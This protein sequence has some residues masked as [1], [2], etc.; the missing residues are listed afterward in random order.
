MMNNGVKPDDIGNVVSLLSKTSSKSMAEKGSVLMA[1]VIIMTTVVLLGLTISG[2]SLMGAKRSVATQRSLQTYY[3]AMAGVQQAMAT[4]FYP[5]SNYLAWNPVADFID[6][7]PTSGNPPDPNSGLVFQDPQNPGGSNVIGAFQYVILGG[8]QGVADS[9][10]GSTFNYWADNDNNNESPAKPKKIG[11]ERFPDSDQARFVIVSRAVTCTDPDGAVQPGFLDDQKLGASNA[12]IP[13]LTPTCTGG[14]EADTLTVVATVWV[15]PDSGGSDRVERTQVYKDDSAI[16]L[17]RKTFLPGIGW[18]NRGA[19]FA[20]DDVYAYDGTG[21]NNP[22]I[23]SHI[24]FYD[25]VDDEIQCSQNI[26]GTSTTI[27]A[28]AAN[29]TNKSVVQLYFKGAIDHRSI[30]ANDNFSWDDCKIDQNDCAIQIEDGGGFESG[31]QMIYQPPKN[32]QIKL[33]PTLG[34]LPGAGA[35]YTITVNTADLRSW[36]GAPGPATPYEIEFTMP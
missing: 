6:P 16:R 21:T 27:G 2:I 32:N 30:D 22:V 31:Y 1:A 29:I 33:L 17:P 7:Y 23:P 25:F 15:K 9:S 18:Q 26:T 10:S 36:S 4:R 24:V 19:T 35:T 13:A 14:M 28:C 20:F 3:V 34:S 5:S 11:F 12:S 8:Y